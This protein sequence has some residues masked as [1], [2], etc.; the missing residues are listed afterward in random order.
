MKLAHLCAPFFF[1]WLE[2][3][4]NPHER[5][6]SSLVRQPDA[7]SSPRQQSAREVSW[8]FHFEYRRRLSFSYDNLPFSA[9]G[10]R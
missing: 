5:T 3:H 7:A 2:Q 9:L 10:S 4:Y 8:P 6:G 1:E